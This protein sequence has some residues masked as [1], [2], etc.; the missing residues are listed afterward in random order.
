MLRVSSFTDTRAPVDKFDNQRALHR[1]CK[2]LA[3]AI[4]TVSHSDSICP[5]EQNFRPEANEFE[6][7]AAPVI[8][9]RR[10]R[11]DGTREQRR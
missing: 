6:A 2:A 9:D 1:A 4:Q 8:F 7:A 5:T 10:T 11:D 3:R